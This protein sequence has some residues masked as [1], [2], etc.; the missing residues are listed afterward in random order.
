MKFLKR[1]FARKRL[2]RHVAENRR[3]VYQFVKNRNAQ[4]SPERRNHIADLITG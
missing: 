4:L 1:Y 3:H 2:A